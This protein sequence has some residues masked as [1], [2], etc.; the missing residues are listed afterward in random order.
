[1]HMLQL[2]SSP[3]DGHLGLFN[4]LAVKNSAGVNV[5]VHM[6]IWIPVFNCFE[7]IPRCRITRLFGNPTF[8]FSKNGSRAIFQGL[9]HFPFLSNA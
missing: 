8:I 4:L 2:V 9:N 1:M 7:C 6:F 3:A 5:S